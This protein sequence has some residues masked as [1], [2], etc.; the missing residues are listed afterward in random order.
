MPGTAARQIVSMLEDEPKWFRDYVAK[1]LNHSLW[2]VHDCLRNPQ[3]DERH[4]LVSEL[5]EDYKF[6][7]KS[8]KEN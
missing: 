2:S 1:I 3:S 4:E 5:K 6:I 7:L 8:L